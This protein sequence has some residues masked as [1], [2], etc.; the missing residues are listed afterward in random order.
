MVQR[1]N[2]I[3]GVM[4]LFAALFLTAAPLPNVLRLPLRTRVQPFKGSADWK[5]VNVTADVA[6]SRAALVICDMWDKHW[7]DGATKRVELLARRAAPIID[8]ARSKGVLIIHAPSETMSHYS[9]DPARLRI[10]EIP[11]VEPPAELD[12]S[13]PP[14]PIDDS[15]GGCDTPNNALP[16]NTR[17][18][19][20]ENPAIRI[21]PADLIS[22]DG[23]EVYSALKHNGIDTLF[24]MGVHTNMCVL[25][26]SF[27]IRQ[28]TKWGIRCILIRDL[29]DAMYNP[30]RRPFVTHDEGTQLVIEHIEKY[31]APTITS[32]D[33]VRALEGN[34]S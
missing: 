22:D 30:A 16:V 25:A 6:V 23:R 21:A 8:L 13:D 3:A 4:V 2:W 26:R 7:C 15:D 1:F 17:V 19:T 11:K 12:L 29:T 9:H 31:W 28:M 20:R 24:V 32:H 33:L 27:A 14:L 10:L 5:A 34:A 18:W